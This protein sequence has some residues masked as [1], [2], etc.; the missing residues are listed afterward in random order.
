MDTTSS[1]ATVEMDSGASDIRKRLTLT[2]RDVSVNVTAPDAAL[3]ETLLSVADPRQITGW[4]L[5]SR[6]PKRTILK[7]ITGQVRPGEMLFVL[8]RPGSGCTSFL[9]VLSNDRDAFDEVVGETRYGSMDHKQAKKYRQQIMFNNEDDVHF[10]T[11]TVN[12]T[13][14]F[15]LRNKV[16]RERPEHL[17]DR[18][19]YVQEK[20]DDILDSLGIPHTKKTLVGNEFIRGVSGGERKRVSLAE[21]MAG[22]SPVQFWDNPTRGLDSKTAV[23]FA[24]MLRREADQNE[25]TI[26]AT[27]YQAG[28]GIYDQ[29]DKVLVLADGMVTYYGPRAMARAYFE[30][31]GFVCPRGANIADFLTS[32][33]VTTERIVAPGMEGKVPNTA[34]EFE[35]YYRQSSICSQMLEDI[36]P[37]EK[38]F[39]EEINL[40]N[41]VLME[42][43]KQ[44][45]PRPQSVYT[46]GL[47]HQVVS[48]TIRQ[49]QILAGD[50]LSIIIKVVSA[51]LQ[52]LV[53]GSLFYN[54]K[55][56][57]S[58]IFLRPGALFF[59]ILYFLLDAMS[60]TTASF[61]G[62]PILSR[63]KRFGFYRPTAFAIAS[64]IT[65]VPIVLVQVSCF[66]LILYFMAALRMDAGRFFTY[67][68]IIVI[69]TLCFLQMFRAIGALCKKF[70]N[71]SK[72][73]GFVSTVF[74]VYGGYLIPFEQM[75][76]W[77]R[78]IFYLNP[79][80]YAF[81]A[82]MANEFVGLELDCV[83]PDYIPYGSGYPAGAS[84]NRGCT[85]KGSTD[86]VINGAAYIREQYSYS[87]HH[88]WRSFGII[89]GFWAFF[90]FLTS[91]GLE[92]NNNQS[93]SSVLLYKRG[94]KPKVADEEGSAASKSEGNALA[95]TGKQSTFTWNHLDYY[96]PFHGEKKQLLHQVFGYVKPGNLV[97]LMGSSG[98]GK[99]TLLD[100]LA[101]RKDS[102]EIVG[103]ILI[104]GRPQG[105]SFQ[106][107]T[108]YCEQ[109]DVHEGTATVREALVFSALLRQPASVP[110]EEKIAYVDHIIDLLELSDIKD[111]LIGVPGAGLSIEQRKRVTLGVELVAKPTLLFLDEP[112][113]GL[114]GQSAYNIIRFL[115]KLVDSGQAVLCTIHQPSA[116]LFDA[117]DSL[118]LLAKGGKMTYFGETGEDSQKV[119]DYFAKNGAPCPPDVNPAEHIVEVIQGNTEKPIDWVDVWSN[120]EEREL[121][122][123]DLEVLNKEAE[124][125]STG[126]E[127]HHD[128]ASPVWFQFKMVLERLMTQL[129]RSP[130]YMWNKIILHVFA[131]LFSGFT[132]WKMGDGTFALQLRLFAIFN[133]IFVA[134]GCIN[135]MQ[136]F[137]LHNRDIFE[138][139]EKKSKTYHWIA[140][141]GA[142]AVSEIP[143]L[144]ICA[145][146]YFACWYFTAGFPVSAYISGHVYLQM[147]FYEFLYTS[148]GQ[149]IAAYAPNEYFAAIMNPILIGAG[150]ISFCGV[151]VPYDQIT[152]FWRYWIYYLDPFTYLVGGLLGEVLWDVKVQCKASEFVQFSAPSGQTCGQYMADFIANNTGYLQDASAT[153]SC[154]FCQYSTGA[155]YAKSFNLKE[156][157]YS[158]RDT[159]ITALFCITSYGLV[160]L[161]MKLRSKKTKSA[162]SE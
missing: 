80:A 49:F 119:L 113:S 149:A 12:R 120:S 96:V 52:A 51:I 15:A 27:M 108:G 162:R 81:E 89:V 19:A 11:L 9:R 107:T 139:R 150:M 69:Q 47:W 123:R 17:Q 99:T 35:A 94:A 45:I 143:Y 115:R 42:K 23:E 29:F 56:D 135:Q 59:A 67:W 83:A 43:R 6:R 109:M 134:P 105:I 36:Q 37:P 63:Q 13:M 20:R 25:K 3:G 97:A 75:H 72:M 58:S 30:D 101:Q 28:N 142:Q 41:A 84:P 127:D 85:V 86:G 14:K 2:F 157:Y 21:M 151:V 133:F 76:V 82:L 39:D 111:A 57:S 141:I 126:E 146:L 18:K 24:R 68:I 147:I 62:R 130:D 65:D 153:G 112:T 5:K 53:C 117:F 95:Q 54:L 160:F 93:G 66:S 145:T 124:A 131:A 40:A 22:Q 138:T 38:L 61:M 106:R 98:A 100:V 102:G 55:L 92:M 44:H 140:F 144:V 71:A 77:F 48:C 60:E 132:F 161:M 16:P 79:G 137:F 155:D 125:N 7:E 121:V 114:D 32:V 148:I 91:L 8:G 129:W 128:F 110:R 34:A 10:P 64:A 159:G 122:L 152:P 154:S 118:V 78:W 103:S 156:K 50:K 116:V 136:P 1:S 33:T 26:V 46:A 90:I 74:F 73:T 88:I 31:M 4:F 70:G 104:D 158:W 87:F